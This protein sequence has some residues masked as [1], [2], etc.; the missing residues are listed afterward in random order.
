MRLSLA[1]RELAGEGG[2]NPTNSTTSNSPNNNNSPTNNTGLI[3][4]AVVIFVSVVAVILLYFL[5]RTIRRKY[6]KPK[7]IPTQFLKRKWQGWHVAT[8][9][10]RAAPEDHW[11]SARES[12]LSPTILDT[13]TPSTSG[14][15]DRNTSV[16]SIATLPPYAYTP[17]PNEQVLGREGERAGIDTVVEYPE[18]AEDE[19]QRR[20]EEME[21]LYQIRVARR[22]EQA[23]RE[24][25]RRQRRE[26]RQRGDTAALEELRL[27]SRL[28]AESASSQN[29]AGASTT[30]LG[31]NSMI[32]EHATRERER[33]VSSVSYA[34][35]GLAK[36]DG[37]RVRAGSVESS[38]PL[39]DSA[40]SM[41]G[42]GSRPGSGMASRN[43]SSS[44]LSTFSNASDDPPPISSRDR[45][46]EDIEYINLG[47]NRTPS[48]SQD[49]P[50][51]SD[52]GDASIPL[53]EP[54]QYTDHPDWDEAPP[55]ESPVR[56][57][58][59]QL[60]ALITLPSIE[61]TTHTP[62]NST[63]ATPVQSR[64]PDSG[65]RQ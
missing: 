34:E 41:G 13:T 2:P 39:L 5:L 1:L 49:T 46:G 65:S 44:A 47:H 26:A 14:G 63:P 45:A 7:Y 37:T 53:S 15:V 50:L 55:Y 30:S 31:S 56:S 10:S 22:A 23:E 6:P 33:R 57:R 27:Q 35:V 36:H 20:E 16:R 38:R 18:T 43:R 59:P 12:R 61:V 29:A 60:P 48:A 40:A 3:V 51:G 9:Y 19:E 21:S 54:P 28:R 52:I 8:K 58:A 4:A 24:R 25:R 17:R 42:G 32:A 11:S 62:N 64:N